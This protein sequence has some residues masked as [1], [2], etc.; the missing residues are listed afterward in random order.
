MGFRV[1]LRWQ[2]GRGEQEN[3]ACGW[4]PKS[5]RHCLLLPEG[6]GPAAAG[7]KHR[8]KSKATWASRKLT[9]PGPLVAYRPTGG[10][11]AVLTQAEEGGKTPER[12]GA[13]LLG[14][15]QE[16]GSGGDGSRVRAGG[17][18]ETSVQVSTDDVPTGSSPIRARKGTEPAEPARE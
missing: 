17:K 12:S 5:R 4:P 16:K 7:R 9:R 8:G 15:I 10:A 14:E 13:G 11:G 18:G 6:P 2:V 3:P 1:R